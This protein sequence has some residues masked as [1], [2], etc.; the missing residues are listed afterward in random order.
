MIDIRSKDVDV[1]QLHSILLGTV[2]HVYPSIAKLDVL[3]DE[4]DNRKLPMVDFV[5]P[6]T[7]NGPGGMDFMPVIGS[8]CIVLES[9]SSIGSGLGIEPIVIGFKP[10][11]GA[12]FSSRVDL[13]PGDIRLQGTK[14]NDVLLR[15]N[16]DIFVVSDDQ[17]L[18]GFLSTQQLVYLR[19]LSFEH[20]LAGGRFVWAITRDSADAPIAY[21]TDIKRALNDASPYLSVRAGASASGGLAVSMHA[22]SL[23]VSD[24]ADSDFVHIVEES[25]GFKLVVG[26]EGETEVSSREGISFET[27]QSFKVRAENEATINAPQIELNTGTSFLKVS[28]YGPL[29]INAPNGIVINTPS[30]SMTTGSDE[31]LNTDEAGREALTIDLLDWL[32]NHVHVMELDTVVPTIAKSSPPLGTPS[33]DLVALISQLT[34]ASSGG[35]PI[36]T[37]LLALITSNTNSVTTSDVISLNTK[38]K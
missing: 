5:S 29:E 30:F 15:N 2:T 10:R 38:V 18:M 4:P 13:K 19:S 31:L 27:L 24:Q 32:Y 22:K 33:P 35:D 21:M 25:I 16:G 1:R 7:A 6:F 8:H 17:T 34:A 11:T 3:L 37:A 12:G 9:T 14:S 23:G 28:D 36:A 20:D 26:S